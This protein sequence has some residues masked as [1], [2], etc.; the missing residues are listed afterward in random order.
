MFSH[1]DLV[2]PILA[3]EGITDLK[4]FRRVLGDLQINQEITIREFAGRY[5]VI[6]GV[7]ILS[8]EESMPCLGIIDLDND[9]GETFSAPESLPIIATSLRDLDAMIVYSSTG[10]D[11]VNQLFGNLGKSM[12]DF[13]GRA[14]SA[15]GC[16]RV[17]SYRFGYALSFNKHPFGNFLD[18]QRFRFDLE[19]FVSAICRDH[20][21]LRTNEVLSRVVEMWC[22][23][24]ESDEWIHH[25][26]G[27]DAHKVLSIGTANLRE[28]GE[29][30]HG[31]IGALMRDSYL[32]KE[33]LST[34]TGV[35]LL[36][37]IKACGLAPV[38][39]EAT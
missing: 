25:V 23:A 24:R 9:H 20:K 17:L 26:T 35:E 29:L 33:F 28:G 14:A 31:K 19:G 1:A 12:Y 3:V 34:P 27:H 6:Q 39:A 38:L 36:D 13:M 11:L 30:S 7:Q 5:G 16:L 22:C 4:F 37:W 10:S 18:L 32:T 15:V 2:G 8:L 21:G